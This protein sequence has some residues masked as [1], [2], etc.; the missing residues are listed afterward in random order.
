MW[1]HRQLSSHSI[2]WTCPPNPSLRGQSGT[3]IQL[4]LLHEFSESLAWK[5]D[6]CMCRSDPSY[7][8]RSLSWTAPSLWSPRYFLVPDGSSLRSASQ[9]PTPPMIAPYL[10]SSGRRR[11]KFKEFV[12]RLETTTSG[13][14]IW[15]ASHCVHCLCWY[16]CHRHSI[17]WGLGCKSMKQRK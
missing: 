6:L 3:Q 11:E 8:I 15:W 17:A 5:I 16:Y 9:K 12:P 14:R 7:F 2:I 13:N 10:G 4:Y 1:F